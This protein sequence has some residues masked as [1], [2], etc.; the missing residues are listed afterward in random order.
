VTEDELQALCEEWQQRL[1]LQDWTVFVRLLRQR[2]MPDENDQAHVHWVLTKRNAKIAIL[3]PIDY[4]PDCWTPQDQEIS[5]VH[6]LLHLHCAG[7]DD[8]KPDH[9]PGIALEQM[10]H[11]VST[12]L[13]M[14]KREPQATS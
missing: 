10:I 3:D 6:E 13:V 4:S 9:P 2:D 5:L 8:F 7:F 11:A 12:A 14:T 1:R